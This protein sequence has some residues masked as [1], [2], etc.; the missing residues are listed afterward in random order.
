MEAIMA[1]VLKTIPET[2]AEPPKLRD[3]DRLSQPE[4][5]RRYEACGK[6]EWFELINGVVYMAAAQRHPHSSYESNLYTLVGHYAWRTP[7]VE[8]LA[9]PSTILDQFN[10]PQ[11]DVALRILDEYGGRS[12]IN[13]EEYVAG[14]PELVI[15]VSHSSVDK[16]LN[17][18]LEVYRDLGVLEYIVVC[19]DPCEFRWFVWPDGE[20]TIDQDGILRSVIFPG[21]W[22]DTQAVLQ[23]RIPEMERAISQGLSHPEHAAF[24][25]L[26][27][28]RKG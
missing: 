25:S 27:K 18:K 24:E 22:I 23:A 9:H 21:L 20:R 12:R 10:E 6:G 2:D 11:P 19:V 26:L 13:A 28:S 7:G 1:S 14:P 17:Q 5:H 16:D 4:F 8:M 3:G 15:E